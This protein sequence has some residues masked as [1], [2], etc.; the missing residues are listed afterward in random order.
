MIPDSKTPHARTSGAK[1]ADVRLEDAPFEDVI[2][3]C[4]KCAA[5][6][7]RGHK[8]KTELRGELKGALKRLGLSKAIRVADTTCLDLCPKNGQTV[9]LGRELAA[10]Q[11]R[12]VGADADGDDVAKLLFQTPRALAVDHR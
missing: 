9:A 1:T 5:K 11:L 3:V 8:G 12:V 10:G 7:G 2:L 4:S 6:L